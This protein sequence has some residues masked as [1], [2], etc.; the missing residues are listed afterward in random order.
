MKFTDI[1]NGIFFP[2]DIKCIVCDGELSFNTK[3]GICDK[4]NK[5][6]YNTKY[7]KCCG[8][9]VGDMTPY[10]IECTNRNHNFDIARAPFVYKGD[11]IKL[12]YRLK[13]G[14]GAYLSKY[15]AQFMYDTLLDSK[16]AVDI[17]TFVP[18]PK[19]REY[20]RGYNQAK[21]IAKELSKL[22]GIPM[23]GLLER[24]KYTKNLARMNKTERL[25]AITDSF[26]I[27]DR[28]EIKGKRI[29]LIDDVFTS[30]ATTNECSRMLKKGKAELVFVLTFAT[31]TDKIQMY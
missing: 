17:I 3:Y 8:R 12:V 24:T 4:C 2:S 6:E 26:A 19:K 7:C 9:H 10:C 18:M 31:S 13:Y 29:L 15:M 16:Q 25:N 30:G 28:T 5:L 27:T 14:H 11:I 23:K 20:E 1:I 21:E 22:S